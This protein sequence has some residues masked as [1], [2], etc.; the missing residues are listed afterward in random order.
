MI[1]REE[2]GGAVDEK[3]VRAREE[4]CF[5]YCRFCS[6]GFS[7]EQKDGSARASANTA[8]DSDAVGTDGWPA[9]MTWLAEELRISR[10]QFTKVAN[11]LEERG[12]AKREQS[13]ENRRTVFSR[14]QRKETGFG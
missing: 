7:D 11:A 10:Q 8:A 3:R 1:A 6:V 4:R 2:G 9:C 13:Q 14:L 12:F 5:V